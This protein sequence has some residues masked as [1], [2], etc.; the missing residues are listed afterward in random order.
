M[1]EKTKNSRS[2]YQKASSKSLN[3]RVDVTKFNRKP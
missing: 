3:N 1:S 2:L